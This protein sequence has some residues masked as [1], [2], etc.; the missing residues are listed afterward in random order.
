MPFSLLVMLLS[1]L[2]LLDGRRSMPWKIPK[3]QLS[4]GW[5]LINSTPGVHKYS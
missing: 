5:Q 1:N 3:W 4:Y 2:D